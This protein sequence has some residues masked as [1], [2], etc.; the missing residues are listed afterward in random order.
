MS[1]TPNQIGREAEEKA[2]K[3]LGGRLVPGSGSGRFIKLDV[4]DAAK[5]IYSVKATEKIRQT[6]MRAIGKLWR[7]AVAGA[8]GYNGHGDG[9]KPAMVF[10]L[11]GEMLVLYRLED[12]AALAT[13]EISPYI[14]PSK[15]AQRR[16]RAS[17]NPRDR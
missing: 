8:R 7:E 14:S 4:N 2:A 5:F 17:E 6:A 15:G 10:E 9:A 12:H 1:R 3:L 13:G 16:Q 11:D